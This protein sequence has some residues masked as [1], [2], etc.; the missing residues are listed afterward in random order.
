ME[1]AFTIFGAYIPSLVF[2]YD[3]FAYTPIS[4]NHSLINSIC[5]FGS[6]IGN[7]ISNIVDKRCEFLNFIHII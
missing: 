4:F 1:C 2:F 3:T 6:S 7:D 5:T